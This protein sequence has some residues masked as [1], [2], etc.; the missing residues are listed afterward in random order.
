MANVDI[1]L[2]T[3]DAGELLVDEVLQIGHWQ[4]RR[5][6]ILRLLERSSSLREIRQFVSTK[7]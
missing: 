6:E 4:A 3:A 7:T 1:D 5:G 2:H